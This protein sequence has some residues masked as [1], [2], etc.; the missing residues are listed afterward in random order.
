[1]SVRGSARAD[2]EAKPRISFIDR[3]S[4]NECFSENAD[5]KHASKPTGRQ[6][7]QQFSQRWGQE[8]YSLKP[9]LQAARAPQEPALRAAAPR[10]RIAQTPES[11]LEEINTLYDRVREICAKHGE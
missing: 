4:E 8:D 6:F 1:M 10:E 7:S 2:R 9:V 11:V 5:L 3:S